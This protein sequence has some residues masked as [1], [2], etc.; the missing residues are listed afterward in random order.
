MAVGADRFGLGWRDDLAGGILANLERIDVLEVIADDYYDAPR[1]RVD[2]L[3][4]LARM[5]PV[6]LHGVGL[7]LASSEAVAEHRLA[8]MA[9]LV[10]RVRPEGWSEHLAFVRGGG[11]EIGHL[12]APPRTLET[13][14][15]AA[16]NLARAERVVGMRPKVENVATLIAPPFSAMSE[17]EWLAAMLDA[18]PCDLLLD[19][20]NLHANAV[21]FGFDAGALLD[22]LDHHRIASI[23]IAGGRWLR[24]G[25]ERRLLDDHL[26][27]VPEPVFALLTE[28]GRRV[29]RPL[30]VVL[31]RDGRFTGVTALL[32]ELERARRALAL[33]RGLA[34]EAA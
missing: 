4:T 14:D 31:E 5:L 7:G 32:E 23:H 24:R 9:R 11:F 26:H 8:A 2:A 12:A 17:A 18:T 22:A 3:A 21:N 16:R 27:E 19:L 13:I 20:H 28:V 1:R 15:G 6:E 29:R 34:A 30:T 10:D 33:G 25:V